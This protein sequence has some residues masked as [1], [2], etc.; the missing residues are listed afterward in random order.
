LILLPPQG[1]GAAVDKPE[2]IAEVKRARANEQDSDHQGGTVNEH[3]GTSGHGGESINTG[4]GSASTGSNAQ[5]NGD[6]MMQPKTRTGT[7]GTSIEG[8]PGRGDTMRG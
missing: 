3:R 8:S 6:G 2:H 7:A 5:G 1:G 4:G